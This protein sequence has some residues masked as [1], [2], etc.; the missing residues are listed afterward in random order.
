M[1]RLCTGAAACTVALLLASTRVSTQGNEPGF[2]AGWNGEARSPPMLYATLQENCIHAGLP[3]DNTTCAL[4]PPSAAA[5]AAAAANP[6]STHLCRQCIGIAGVI[7]AMTAKN[8]TATPSPA[9]G[10]PSTA[11]SQSLSLADVGYSLL[12]IDA[13]ALDN[14]I[15]R[16][17]HHATHDKTGANVFNA[18]RFPDMAAVVAHG[19]ARGLRMGWTLN[20]GQQEATCL[21]IN[22][23]GDVRQLHDLGFDHVRLFGFGPCR[24]STKYASLMRA[25]GRNYSIANQHW[26]QQD[27]DAPIGCHPNWPQF[28]GGDWASCPSLDWCPFNYYQIAADTTASPASWFA[29]LQKV[30]PYTAVAA[31]LSRPGCWAWLGQLQVGYVMQPHNNTLLDLPWNRAHF[32]AWCVVSS[33]LMLG[34]NLLK[35]GADR[36]AL[37]AVA[38]VITNQ[39]AIRVNQDWVGSPGRLLLSSDPSNPDQPDAAHFVRFKGALGAAHP[40]R[41]ANASIAEAEA[42]CGAAPI[43]EGFSF[44]VAGEKA[45]QGPTVYFVDGTGGDAGHGGPNNGDPKWVTYLKYKYVGAGPLAQQW[46]GKPLSGGAWAVL[47]INGHTNRTYTN[48]ALPLTLLNM[49]SGPQPLE[50]ADIWTGNVLH[51]MVADGVFTPPPVPPRD[52]AFYKLSPGRAGAARSAGV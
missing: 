27:T 38:P 30:V 4:P 14:N 50:V 42:W 39:A 43:C 9:L 48:P 8:W 20:E 44:A 6:Q 3:G 21:G 19:H 23:E 13:G 11:V 36:A 7:T 33:P 51:G 52:S 15:N 25:T 41:R 34:T 28:K 1:Q 2:P 17:S 18:A 16:S 32:A 47:A 35:A 24:N 12:E 46:W 5:A 26:D 45:P 10:Y 37:A 49:S 29:N 31:P 40:L 22:M